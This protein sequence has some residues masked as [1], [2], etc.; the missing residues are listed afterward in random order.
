MIECVHMNKEH[1]TTLSAFIDNG[2]WNR[3]N[4]VNPKE[5]AS[6]SIGEDVIEGDT[7]QTEDFSYEFANGFRTQFLILL[8]RMFLQMSRNKTMI[9]IQII[10]HLISGGLLGSIFFGIG[11]DAGMAVSNFNFCLSVMVF[12]VYTHVMVPVLLCKLWASIVPQI[13]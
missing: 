12:F 5:L 6:T 10:H 4:Y 3:R 2:K 9:W 7:T 8:G 1:T 11:N 13:T